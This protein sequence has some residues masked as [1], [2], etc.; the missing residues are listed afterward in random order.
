MKQK[1]KKKSVIIA[2]A[3][4]IIIISFLTTY[5]IL[6]YIKMPTAQIRRECK[7]EIEEY[8]NRKVYKI[9]SKE[10]TNSDLVIFY[11][12][13][14]SY[15]G[16]LVPEH[17]D[18]L[19]DL[20]KDTNATIL[21]PDYPL[22]PYANYEEVFKFVEPLYKKIRQENQNTKFILMGDSAGGGLAL[23]LAEKLGEEVQTQP[24]KI[25]LLSPWLDVT[26]T[27]PKITE[28]EKKDPVLKVATL[29]AAGLLYAGNNGIN[30]YLVN[31]VNGPIENLN[32]VVILTGTNDIL[33]PDAHLLVE[34]A[35]KQGVTI[36]LEEME[37][38]Q[39]VWM[40]GRYTGVSLAEEGYQKVIKE[41]KDMEEI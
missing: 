19:R 10:N 15:V 25:I 40:L 14:G 21:V 8:Q 16:N 7:M 17:W 35:A 28:I 3:I 12:H 39:H 22:V 24:D 32:N 26:M 38:A 30:S 1:R 2:I 6:E 20:I 41:I 13:G 33:N 5:L 31:P 18:F 9:S 27:N 23:A 11:L 37:G 34:R 29:K 4:T 36:R